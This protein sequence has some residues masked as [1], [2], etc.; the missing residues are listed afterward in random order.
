[1]L[2]LS[3]IIAARWAGCPPV[4]H[5]RSFPGKCAGHSEPFSQLPSQI[6]KSFLFPRAMSQASMLSRI[7]GD[8]R[9]SQMPRCPAA[10]QT[11]YF[12]ACSG[13]SDNCQFNTAYLLQSG[14]IIPEIPLSFL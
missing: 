1:M 12:V 13:V 3:F 8:C 14:F 2:I 10:L 11:R 9:E 5:L 4:L 6:G 7:F